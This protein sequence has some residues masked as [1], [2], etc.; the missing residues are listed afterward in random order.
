MLPSHWVKFGQLL[1][2]GN[3]TVQLKY[4]SGQ[5]CQIIIDIVANVCGDFFSREAT[6]FDVVVC[7]N[8]MS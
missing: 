8:K 2:Y 3:K 5:Y 7:A 6:F 1:K 4:H